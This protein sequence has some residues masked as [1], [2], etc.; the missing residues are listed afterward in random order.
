VIKHIPNI[1]TTIRFLLIGVF[2]YCFLNGMYLAALI[3]FATAT[4]TD[5]AD[6]YIA[7]KYNVITD[8]GKLMDPAADKLMHISAIYCL[9]RD[10]YLHFS[11]FYLMLVKEGLMIIGGIFLYRHEVVVYSH[12]IGKAATLVFNIGL[13]MTFLNAVL[14]Q[15]YLEPYNHIVVALGLLLTYLALIHYARVNFV[16]VFKAKVKAFKQA[17]IDKNNKKG[18]EEEE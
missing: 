7:R 1:L 16:D 2:V 12:F 4:I 6:G 10:G 8:F 13:L 3:V 18:V 17:R 9:C 15:P 5:W 14:A 11:I